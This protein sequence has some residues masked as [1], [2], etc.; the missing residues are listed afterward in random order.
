MPSDFVIEKK[1]EK[2]I[3]NDFDNKT[4]AIY[5]QESAGKC[6]ANSSKVFSQCKV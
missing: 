5:T 6:T 4:I 3:L 1:Q 2:D